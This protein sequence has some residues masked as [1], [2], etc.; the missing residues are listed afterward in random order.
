M[1][2]YVC[3]SH[4]AGFFGCALICILVLYYGQVR[5]VEVAQHFMP[6]LFSISMG[7]VE[8]SVKHRIE[9]LRNTVEAAEQFPTVQQGQ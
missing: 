1:Q 7:L 2:T 8:Y 3:W 5:A 4:F 6:S 9:D